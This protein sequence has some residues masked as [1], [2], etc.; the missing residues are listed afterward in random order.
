ML[1]IRTMK[2]SIITL[3]LLLAAAVTLR[4]AA[5]GPSKDYVIGFYNLE[6][7]FDTYDDPAK[8]D[9]DF[10]PEGRNKWTEP[11]YR[12]KL[13]NTAAVIKAMAKKNGSFHTVLGVSEVENR[14]VL[15]D[16][17][18]QPELGRAGYRIVHYDSPDNRGIDV[19]LLYRPD[20]FVY[21]ESESIPFT[22]DSEIEFEMDEEN[23]AGF[24]TRDILMVH[25]TIEG[26]DFAFYVAHLPSRRGGKGGDL[27]NRGAEIIHDHAMEMM[28]KY[29]GIK[30]VVMGDMNDNPTDPS[31]SEF[32]HGREHVS[33]VGP[34]DFFSPFFSMLGKGYG[35]LAYRGEWSI[36]DLILV[37]ETL[38]D[39]PEGG[40]EIKE[41]DSKGN[42]GVVFRKPFMVNKS[43]KYKGYPYRSFA[44]GEFIGGYSDHF[45]TYIIVGK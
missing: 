3:F 37:N 28:E 27:R 8:D 34:S 31:M 7:L 43:G 30:I 22:F 29:P 40:L 6:N 25:G 42:Y 11:K 26:E 21:E 33:E 36:Y 24:R 20:Q 23:R 39:A 35:T 38:L 17:V 45:P 9:E 19:A 12:Q 14:K 2:R 44:G 10:L 18:C 16:L 41:A 13:H 1:N 5:G 15:E 32:L 4:I